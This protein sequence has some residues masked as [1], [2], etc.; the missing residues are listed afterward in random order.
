M[1]KCLAVGMKREAVQQTRLQDYEK[2]RKRQ[3]R[4]HQKGE[5]RK[6]TDFASLSDFVFHL[7]AVE[8]YCSSRLE[9]ETSSTSSNIKMNTSSKAHSS[10]GRP[11]SEKTREMAARLLFMTVHWAKKV[12]HF[13]ELSHFDQVT[14]LRENWCKV[15]IINLA[16][17]AMPQFELA[18]L[19][20][21]ATEKIP[22]GHLDKVLKNMGKLN[23][24]VFKLVQLRMDRAEFSLLKALALFNPDTEHLADTVQIQAIQ[25]KTQN[26]LE[27]YIRMYHHVPNRFGQTLLRLVAL[28]SVESRIIEHV[29][30]NELLGGA[31]IYTLVDGILRTKDI[32]GNSE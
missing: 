16:Q 11:S 17:W 7:Q 26:A 27:E 14:L 18:P 2:Q 31:S 28:G 29:F 12:K 24:I 22:N 21:D 4:Q 1:R 32:H 5:I 25:N 19:V 6:E 23:E 3:K 30:F 13:S 15:F 10:N 8:P 9:K 20:D